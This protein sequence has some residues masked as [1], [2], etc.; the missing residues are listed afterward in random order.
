MHHAGQIEA[1]PREF[2]DLDQVQLEAADV[3]CGCLIQR[4]IEELGE[5]LDMAAIAPDRIRRQM[6]NPH[7]ANHTLDEVGGIVVR[8]S[9]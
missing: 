2:S 6:A 3:F 4:S 5:L 1:A 8:S 9:G 7:V